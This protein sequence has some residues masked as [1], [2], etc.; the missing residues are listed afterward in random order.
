ME[1]I[2][3]AVE[4]TRNATCPGDHDQAW[5]L[6]TKATEDPETASELGFSM[7]SSPDRAERKIG[8]D[9]LG[10]LAQIDESLREPVLFA[11]LELLTSETDHAVHASIARTLGCTGDERA[12]PELLRLADHPDEDVRDYVASSLPM[13][14]DAS[15]AVVEVL[16]RLSADPEDDVRNWATFALG[17]QCQADSMAIREALWA[18]VDDEFSEVREEAIAGLARR[19]DR[20]IVPHAARLLDIGGFSGHTLTAIACLGDP[21]LVP[22]LEEYEEDEA[23]AEALRECDPEAR[24]ARDAFAADLAEALHA[25][26]PELDFGVCGEI[27]E[28][29][30]VL[31]LCGNTRHWSVEPLR[32]RAG[33]DPRR[34]A[35]LVAGEL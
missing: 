32:D 13:S 31:S 28:P 25:R 6:V 23:V 3:E 24:A 10:S 20:R 27:C 26:M 21:A 16:I 35:E 14:R 17:T 33:G 7:L 2:A 15:D 12:I 1:L 30:L 5:E 22:Y 9:L 8:C 19:R 11:V 18:R 29:G 4:L 34:A